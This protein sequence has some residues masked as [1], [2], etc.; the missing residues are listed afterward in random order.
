[1]EYLNKTI[2]KYTMNKFLKEKLCID[3]IYVI[4]VPSEIERRI[5]ILREMN[6]YGIMVKIVDALKISDP[7][8][9]T[10]KNNCL[11]YNKE[12]ID[13]YSN[14]FSEQRINVLQRKVTNESVSYILTHL[15]IFNDAIAMKYKRILVF[16]DDVFFDRN[17]IFKLMR[18]NEFIKNDFKILLLGASEYDKNHKKHGSHYI[19][20]VSI[21]IYNPIADKTCGSFAVLYNSS[22]FSEIV[23]TIKTY[24]SPYDN[25]ILGYIYNRYRKQCYVI[26]PAICIPD[27]Q[28]STIIGQSRNQFEHSKK[29]NWNYE[30]YKNFIQKFSLSILIEDYE[31]INHN[32]LLG[33]DLDFINLRI[34]YLSSDGI[35]PIIPGHIFRPSDYTPMEIGILSSDKTILNCILKLNI[36]SSDCII[37]WKS[38]QKITDILILNYLDFCMK[39]INTKM[40]NISLYDNN[41]FIFN[42]S[43]QVFEDKHSIIIPSY[44]NPIECYKSVVSALNQ[45][46]VDHEVI[47]VNDNPKTDN[48]DKE[49]IRLCRMNCDVDIEDKLIIVNHNKNRNA[50]A[51]RNTGFFISTGSYI[52]FLDD[53]DLYDDMRL[54]RAQ[55][56]LKLNNSNS[57]IGGL[58]CGYTGKWNGIINND[59]FKNGNLLKNIIYLDYSSH[60]LCTNTVT[61]NRYAFECL[62]GYNESYFR[63]QDVELHTRFFEKFDIISLDKFLVNNRPF[64]SKSTFD[65]N[66]MNLLSLKYMYLHDFRKLIIKY[67][68]SD[69]SR[70]IKNHVDDICKYNHNIDIKYRQLIENTLHLAIFN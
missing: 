29:M 46:K 27:V 5:R 49:L 65:F 23:N 19:D 24:I 67:F 10:Y 32:E 59:R 1:M 9:I 60:Y 44:R 11:I 31:V 54:Y 34:Y 12:R 15:K 47:V 26:E 55:E 16:D 22:I 58:Y 70:L 17:F 43:R 63:H 3:K 20:D 40:T 48:F 21:S 38:Q 14:I 4:N 56:K 66:L 6:K 42:Y 7:E 35:R 64:E 50:S 33:A 28:K 37:I 53:D 2:D 39:I 57:K 25:A 51:A 69:I 13:F 41:I 62:N 52:S 18:V 68:H 61:F 8:V 36:P 30:N 45:K